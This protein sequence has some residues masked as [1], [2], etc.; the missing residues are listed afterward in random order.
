MS[1]LR[2][3]ATSTYGFDTGTM[4][5]SEPRLISMETHTEE[6]KCVSKRKQAWNGKVCNPSQCSYPQATPCYHARP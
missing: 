4:L 2:H 6:R 1:A 5:T 3:D